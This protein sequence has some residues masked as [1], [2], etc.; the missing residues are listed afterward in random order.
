[1]ADQYRDVAHFLTIYISE[2]HPDDGWRLQE[3]VRDGFVFNEPKTWE[4]RSRL[5][6][7]FVERYAWRLPVAVD[8]LDNRVEQ[9]YAA[10]PDRLYVIA[11][12]GRI[13]YK[14]KPGPFG[15]K[16]E[17]VSRTLDGISEGQ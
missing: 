4:E 5:A 17:E 7:V 9:D 15:F 14:G 2:A 1:V 8:N 13:L 10:W 11:R 3:N 12:G 6:R 16:P